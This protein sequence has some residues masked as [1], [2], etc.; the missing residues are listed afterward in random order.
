M[1]IIGAPPAARGPAADMD[2]PQ[3]TRLRRARWRNP[4]LLAGV[5]LV[6]VST[7]AGVRIVAGA[8]DTVPVLVAVRDLSPGLPLTG[9]L[10]EVR[11]VA[12]RDAHEMYVPG[13]VRGD[14]VLRREV[15]AGE[16]LPV[17][18]VATADELAGGAG[19][20]R[21]LALAVP[22]GEAPAGLGTGDVVDVWL[23]PE[24]EG[25]AELAASSLTLASAG[26]DGT[27]GVSGGQTAVTVAVEA[28]GEEP[29]EEL[30]GR[31]VA[32]S[33][34]GRIYLSRLP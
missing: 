20:L 31:L 27:F 30:V 17:S 18:A 28:T 10:V 1:V 29:L 6:L 23:T 25:E 14:Y 32:A 34:D 21:L 9:E 33:R 26:A 19:S 2:A 16:L 5:L 22:S 24:G 12:L 13:P 11:Q 7:V 8:D 4:Q 15:S 3:A